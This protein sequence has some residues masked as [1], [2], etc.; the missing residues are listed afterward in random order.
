MSTISVVRRRQQAIINPYS[1]LQF[2][3]KSRVTKGFHLSSPRKP[4][5]TKEDLRPIK[6]ENLIPSKYPNTTR[7][8]RTHS[9]HDHVTYQSDDGL[10]NIEDLNIVGE[11]MV[12]SMN[13]MELDF[14]GTGSLFRLHTEATG[15]SFPR[16][17]R[18]YV[19]NTVGNH[20]LN[21]EEYEGD[22]LHSPTPRCDFEV[23]MQDD[24]INTMPTEKRLKAYYIIGQDDANER[25]DAGVTKKSSAM[26]YS[27]ASPYAPPTTPFASSPC[28]NDNFH[29]DGHRLRCNSNLRINSARDFTP[30]YVKRTSYCCNKCEMRMTGHE[31]LHIETSSPFYAYQRRSGTNLTPC[32]P[33]E[34]TTQLYNFL[35]CQQTLPASL[36]YNRI[37]LRYKPW[38]TLQSQGQ[39]KSSISNDS[40][41]FDTDNDYSDQEMIKQ[42]IFLKED[43]GDIH[44]SLDE[45]ENKTNSSVKK[46]DWKDQ[47]DTYKKEYAPHDIPGY[48]LTRNRK[49]EVADETSSSSSND[50]S[51]DSESAKPIMP[52]QKEWCA[53]WNVKNI[54]PSQLQSDEN[55]EGMVRKTNDFDEV[56]CHLDLRGCR[57]AQDQDSADGKNYPGTCFTSLEEPSGDQLHDILVNCADSLKNVLKNADPETTISMEDQSGINL[58]DVSRRRDLCYEAMTDKRYNR[59]RRKKKKGRHQKSDELPSGKGSPYTEVKQGNDSPDQEKKEE[60]DSPLIVRNEQSSDSKHSSNLGEASSLRDALKDDKEQLMKDR[61]LLIHQTDSSLGLPSEKFP[62]DLQ[63][64]LTSFP[65]LNDFHYP[66]RRHYISESSALNNSTVNRSVSSKS[67]TKL[68]G[69]LSYGS[70]RQTSPEIISRAVS[71]PLVTMDS[72]DDEGRITPSSS[73]HPKWLIPQNT[74]IPNDMQYPPSY[75]DSAA[76]KTIVRVSNSIQEKIY[77]ASSPEITILRSLKTKANKDRP[78]VTEGSP[79]KLS[80]QKKTLS[81]SLKM[82]KLD[83]T[84]TDPEKLTLGHLLQSMSSKNRGRLLNP[85]SLRPMQSPNDKNQEEELK[86]K[87]RRAKINTKKTIIEE[88]K[89]ITRRTCVGDKIPALDQGR[90]VGQRSNSTPEVKAIKLDSRPVS[91]IGLSRA[92]TYS[93]FQLPQDYKL[94][95]SVIQHRRLSQ[96]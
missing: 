82:K 84:H 19:H 28:N 75:Y 5:G 8:A 89:S 22:F 58:Q 52:R 3:R 92:F 36:R 46:T 81:A 72:G 25:N 31:S 91:Q 85:K 80:L 42:N 2:P 71:P 87:V 45:L 47:V 77:K 7:I 39:T 1:Q 10:C 55:N 56:L 24:D 43:Y 26:S 74:F 86:P 68:R 63:C 9:E 73:I 88:E 78:V 69:S 94:N 57:M 41:E 83:E 65:A 27:V 53:M 14:P 76:K 32:S 54:L 90:P 70:P 62:E 11:R 13:G 48:L 51:E 33:S 20:F 12:Q 59:W 96:N 44:F 60:R 67:P 95:N 30:G 15:I 40:D 61:S 37:C 49:D 35:S 38:C 34:S 29:V 64:E 6:G 93:Y 16:I 18:E 17:H 4:C 23:P 50:E 21:Q 79:V 66:S